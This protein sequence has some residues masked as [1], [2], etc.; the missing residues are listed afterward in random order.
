MLQVSRDAGYAE[1]SMQMRVGTGHGD[2]WGA[3]ERTTQVIETDNGATERGRRVIG[4]DDGATERGRR[5][6]GTDDGATERGW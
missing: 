1:L 5:V 2:G 6:I 4:T 3:T